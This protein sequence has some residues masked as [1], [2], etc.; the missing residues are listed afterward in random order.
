M[1]LNLSTLALVAIAAGPAAAQLSVTKPA[2]L[3]VPV[4]LGPG[5]GAIIVGFRRP[6]AQ[7]LGKSG[8]LAFTRYDP[9][10]HDMIALPKGAR[11]NGDTNTYWI[12]VKARN[13]KA[14]LE[15]VV[16][17]VSAGDYVLYG[18]MSGPVPQVPNSFCLKSVTFRVNA[19][20]TVYFG[21]ITPYISVRLVDG[22]Q[23]PAMAYSSHF[24][25]ARAALAAQPA[26][27]AALKPADIRNE[28][29]FTCSAEIMTA[30]Q[31]PGAPALPPLAPDARRD[32]VA[33]PRQVA[34][35]ATTVIPVPS[36]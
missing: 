29:S 6:D 23:T 19:G 8:L 13:K 30:Y 17:V 16:S 9:Q 2:N 3:A 11:K 34:P 20:E 21:D 33:A 7:S 22:G 28:A 32:P 5:Q 14:P 12:E 10:A 18:A 1:R 31:V 25:D 26:L 4:A 24:D 35:A 36:N 15:H 27:L